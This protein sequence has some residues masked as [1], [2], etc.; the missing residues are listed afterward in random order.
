MW[1]EGKVS[2]PAL[3]NYRR[4]CNTYDPNETLDLNS[5]EKP[6]MVQHLNA[7]MMRI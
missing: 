4:L 1:R 6:D 3:E 5:G 7:A 2:C